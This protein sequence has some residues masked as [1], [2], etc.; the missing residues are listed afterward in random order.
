MFVVAL[1]ASALLGLEGGACA[2]PYRGPLS[3]PTGLSGDPAVSLGGVPGH[4]DVPAAVVAPPSTFAISY[5]DALQ[6]SAHTGPWRQQ[7]GFLAFEFLPR[8]TLSA[9]A[10]VIDDS[11]APPLVD[12]LRDLSANVQFLVTHESGAWPALALGALDINGAND[13][14]N[15]RYA[16]ATKTWFGRIRTTAGY[17]SGRLV[18]G[19]IGGVMLGLC[20]GISLVADYEDGAPSYGIRASPFAGTFARL[21]FAP[22]VD[23]VRY[24]NGRPVVNLSAHFA[25]PGGDLVSPNRADRPDSV[26]A[27]RWHPRADGTGIGRGADAVA[28]A[29]TARGFE[30]VRVRDSIDVLRVAYEN[31]VFWR[32]EWAAFGRVLG[33][34]V[35]H[36]PASTTR[37]EVVI[38]RLDLA[39]MRVE[40]PIAA[41]R[42]FLSG[43]LPPAGFARVM[44]VSDTYPGDAA[45]ED[46]P[47]ANR[48][49][50]RVD[51][52][53]RPRVETLVMTESSPAEARVSVLPEAVAQLG[54]GVT[55]TARRAIEVYT[56]E[57]FWVN[58][59]DPNAD[60]L[61]V[62][63]AR[64]LPGGWLAGAI[65]QLSVGRF[66][67]REVGAA[68]EVLLP[69]SG[70]RVSLG[71]VIA[72]FGETA[73]HPDRSVALGKVR[74][75]DAPTGL[76]ASVTAGRFLNGDVGAA[77][78]VQRLFGPAEV[79]FGLRATNFQSVAGLRVTVPLGLS[80]N[81]R[82]APLRVT[83]PGYHTQGIESTVLARLPV[84]RRDVGIPLETG[85]DL[86]DA[87]RARDRL[88]T[89][90][91][92]AHLD[93]VRDAA[94]QGRR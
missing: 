47:A 68:N 63:V 25:L 9:R 51:V 29:L 12:P 42:D 78:E 82:P 90:M 18:H 34:V 94:N 28:R 17:A 80:R 56:T 60:R 67:H 4:F 44:Q 53:A 7:N 72:V 84:L 32:D 11:L 93:D 81:V 23:V 24:R 76:S 40:M 61:L 46:A 31:R 22:S 88:Y 45:L 20:G 10:A 54:R 36:A 5:N 65:S 21:G 75:L 50:W 79:A 74:L 86:W 13:L 33:D 43:I 70:G 48:S 58:V 6:R 57:R 55:I 19:V 37:I 35:D 49:A 89:T 41:A 39:V 73:A 91:L 1:A 26:A 69:L 15:A 87:V 92:L 2:S 64:P 27:A 30:N 85:N 52:T 14:Y 66:G 77:L 59:A 8:L 38:L 83:W 3:A 71:G 62:N 16:V